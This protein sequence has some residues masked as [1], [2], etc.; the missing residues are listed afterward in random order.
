MVRGHKF[1]FLEDCIWKAKEPHIG[2]WRITKLIKRCLR[3]TR[4]KSKPAPCSSLG[5]VCQSTLPDNNQLAGEEEI[6]HSE[7]ATLL[8]YILT[9]GAHSGGRD[10]VE[11][12]ELTLQV[13][14]ACQLYTI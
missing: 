9:M 3:R 5:P 6:D 12:L 1:V 10:V 7:R 4:K 8:G 14:E 11:R 13:S 2:L